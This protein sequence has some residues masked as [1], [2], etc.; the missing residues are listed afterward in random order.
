MLSRSTLALLQQAGESLFSAQ[1]AMAQEVHAGS[2]SVVNAVASAPFSAE[3]DRAYAQ[4][5]TVARLSHELQAMEEQ[6]RTA[7]QT[8]STLAQREVQV[9]HALPLSRATAK[10]SRPQASQAEDVV[11]KAAGG[12][13]RAAR[14][15]APKAAARSSSSQTAQSSPRLSTN[16]EK[17]LAY[18]E[19]VLNRE[20]S[21]QITQASVAQG[22][23]IPNGS[24]AVALKRLQQ[25]GRVIEGERG[26]Y[27]LG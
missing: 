22:A 1:Q 23:G 24:I 16:D 4:L 19:R 18:L 2:Q 11:V 12:K 10:A 6:L 25:M 3:A 17:V 15:S 21:T 26:H 13:R 14:A 8:A 20:T 5:R 27:R 9:L 7:Y